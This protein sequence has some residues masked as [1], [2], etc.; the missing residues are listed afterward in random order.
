VDKTNP[1]KIRQWIKK[2][3]KKKA[4]DKTNPPKKN[5]G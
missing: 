5:S 3:A 4:V 2:P 1:P